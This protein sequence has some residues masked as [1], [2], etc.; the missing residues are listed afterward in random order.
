VN[1]PPKTAD[2][3]AKPVPTSSPKLKRCEASE[4]VLKIVFKLAIDMDYACA[5][6]KHGMK[7]KTL[8]QMASALADSQVLVQFGFQVPSKDTMALWI[9]KHCTRRRARGE[10]A[11]RRAARVLSVSARQ[12][13]K[14]SPELGAA[15]SLAS[16][17]AAGVIVLSEASTDA[18][19]GA[20]RGERGRRI[21]DGRSTHVCSNIPLGRMTG[22]YMSPCAL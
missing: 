17:Y 12:V 11:A 4:D 5:K 6:E 1:T 21:C 20:R 13:G 9:D 14:I 19:E 7:E 10:R 22:W 8:K 3:A 15:S 18:I 16:A 2:K